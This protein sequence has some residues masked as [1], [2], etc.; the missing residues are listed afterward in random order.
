M[1]CGDVLGPEH[2]PV[3]AVHGKVTQR[4][5]P[6][7][8]GWIE[9]VPVDGTVGKMRSA[10]LDSDGSFHATKVPVG[11]NLIRFVNID[12]DPIQMRR[13][14]GTFTSQIRRQIAEKDNPTLEIDLVEEYLKLTR[15]PP[16][17]RP[18]QPTDERPE[19]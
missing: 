5:K 13:I 11:L 19:R 9:F 2:M 1:G 16:R 18:G 12:W 15:S 4:H 6:V 10:R 8:R 17:D 14:F 7:T 3:A